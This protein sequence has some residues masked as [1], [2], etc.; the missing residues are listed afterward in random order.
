MNIYIYIYI[1]I[2]T[3][4]HTHTCMYVHI[5]VYMHI[6]VYAHI[7]KGEDPVAII[8]TRASLIVQSKE[9]KKNL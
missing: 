2:Y 4:T 5:R 1:Y 8:E 6:R 3:H 9:K 7:E